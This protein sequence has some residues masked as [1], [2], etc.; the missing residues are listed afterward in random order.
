MRRKCWRA[1]TV[2]WLAGSLVPPAGM[3]RKGAPLPSL[4]RSKAKIEPLSLGR[5]STAPAPSPNSTQ[6][7][8]S[9]QSSAF[10][11][12]SAPVTSTLS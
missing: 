8:R 2:S 9:C 12:A 5:T 7:L 10:E 11:T 4:P 6:V 1:S 3:L